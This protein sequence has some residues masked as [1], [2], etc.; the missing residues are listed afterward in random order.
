MGQSAFRMLRR[1]GQAK[2]YGVVGID[3][4]EPTYL[5]TTIWK[6]LASLTS[7]AKVMILRSKKRMGKSRH[8]SKPQ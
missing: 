8:R 6:D 4:S 2:G 1:D 5:P 7:G 3:T